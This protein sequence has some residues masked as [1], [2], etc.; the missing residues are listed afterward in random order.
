MPLPLVEYLKELF[1]ADWAKKFF[2]A[3]TE[4]VEKP[5]RFID[6]PKIIEERCIQCLLC[7]KSCP[8]D[9][10]EVPEEKPIL[11]KDRCIRCGRCVAVCPTKTLISVTEHE[12]K[13]TL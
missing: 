2:N 9:A 5:E 7:E 13:E 8:V 11:D 6:F 12:R 4:P 10:I 3:K 1:N